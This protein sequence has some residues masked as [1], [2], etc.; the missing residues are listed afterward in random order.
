MQQIKPLALLEGHPAAGKDTGLERH[1]PF[2]SMSIC[3]LSKKPMPLKRKF[4][5]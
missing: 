5:G 1:M 3:I 4:R 2:M